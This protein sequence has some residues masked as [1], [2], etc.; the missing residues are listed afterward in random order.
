MRFNGGISV[1]AACDLCRAPTVFPRRPGAAPVLGF[2]LALLAAGNIA[3]QTDRDALMALYR[4]TSGPNWHYDSNWGSGRPLGEW[5]G[6]TTNQNGRVTH[7]ELR[8]NGLAGPISPELGALAYLESLDISINRGLSGPIP[9]ALG[10][11]SNLE[12]L[13]LGISA[14]TGPIPRSWGA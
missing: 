3:A 6:V 5:Y 2:V 1:A 14:L 12:V 4:A 10:A 11:L 13:R 9:A 8:L 7:L